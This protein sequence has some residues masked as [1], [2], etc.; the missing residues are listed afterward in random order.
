MAYVRDGGR[1]RWPTCRLHLSLNSD[2]E[3]QLANGH[4][5]CGGRSKVDP[6]D[7]SKI[8]TVCARCHGELHVRIG[9]IRKRIEGDDANKTLRFFER[10]DN[11]TWHEVGPDP[12]HMEYTT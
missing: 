8:V 9:G 4:E 5:I 11:I 3:F 7:P 10:I 1:C 12:N 2:N 6:T